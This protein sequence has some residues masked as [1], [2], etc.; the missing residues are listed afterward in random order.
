MI[1]WDEF[2]VAADASNG[3]VYFLTGTS[4]NMYDVS[5]S[6]KLIGKDEQVV[7]GDSGYHAALCKMKSKM[8]S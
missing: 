3:Y 6:S 2:F 1:L 8:I 4:S 7:Y 5:K